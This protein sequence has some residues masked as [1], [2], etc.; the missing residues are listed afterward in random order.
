MFSPMS[1]NSVLCLFT[2]KSTFTEYIYIVKM[3]LCEQ[4]IYIYI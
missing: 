1:P 3:I 4:N 2:E